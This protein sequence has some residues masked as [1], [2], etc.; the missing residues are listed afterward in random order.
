MF[1]LEGKKNKTL[2]SSNKPAWSYFT[3]SKNTMKYNNKAMKAK[4]DTLEEE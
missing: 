3:Q 4:Q 2:S 1:F